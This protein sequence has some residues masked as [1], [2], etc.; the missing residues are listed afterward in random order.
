MMLE[1]A[2]LN[3]ILPKAPMIWIDALSELLP[4]STIDSPHEVASFLAQVA[5]ESNEF[6]VLEENLNYSALRLMA[7]WPKRFPSLEF[8][9]AYAGFP[10]KIANYVYANRIGN[11]NEKS[12]DGWR[13]RG[14]GP[15]QITGKNNYS[16][17]GIYV[18][19]HLCDYPDQLLTPEIGI[20]SAIWYWQSRNLDRLDDDSDVAPETRLI[21]GSDLGLAQRQAYFNK[22][23][24][25]LEA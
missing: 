14:R 4:G 5:H 11:G 3:L 2:V 7:V 12:G 20:K 23:L 16:A 10:E 15:I 1:H 25:I 9:Q 21:N 8:T 13:F 22:A 24:E 19:Y 18:N 17:C 6:T